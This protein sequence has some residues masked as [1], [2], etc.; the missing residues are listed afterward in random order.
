MHLKQLLEKKTLDIKIVPTPCAS[1]PPTQTIV[2]KM[3]FKIG[4]KFHPRGVPDAA[5]W[6]VGWSIKILVRTCLSSVF[7]S[8][9][10]RG[11]QLQK[12]FLYNISE[13]MYVFNSPIW[14][15]ILW[16]L[17]SSM[18]ATIAPLLF[19]AGKRPLISSLHIFKHIIVLC[20]LSFWRWPSPV[21]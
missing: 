18:S 11:L 21:W 19:S 4:L 20:R 7:L 3:I 14:V 2:L 13:D 16:I 10:L 15:P 5:R 8:V 17:A 9:Y 6:L 12:A 1:I